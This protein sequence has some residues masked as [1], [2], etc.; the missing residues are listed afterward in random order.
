MTRAEALA[1]VRRLATGL[2]AEEDVDAI[3]ARFM[4]RVAASEDGELLRD[5]LTELGAKALLEARYQ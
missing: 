3:V 4:E 5:V 2:P 1:A